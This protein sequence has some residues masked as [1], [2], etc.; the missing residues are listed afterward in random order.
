[1][2]SQKVK[3]P[4]PLEADFYPHIRQEMFCGVLV[5]VPKQGI[6]NVEQGTAELRSGSLRHSI[7]LVRYSAVQKKY[8]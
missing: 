7:F 2:N 1:M 6:S 3:N 4:L 8:L 5:I